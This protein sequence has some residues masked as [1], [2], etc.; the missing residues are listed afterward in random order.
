LLVGSDKSR[1]K[2]VEFRAP[3]HLALDQ[4]QPGD[5]AFCLAISRLLKNLSRPQRGYDSLCPQSK[6]EAD[7]G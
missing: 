6:G 1:F 4:L 5:L 2:K 3:I 7:A